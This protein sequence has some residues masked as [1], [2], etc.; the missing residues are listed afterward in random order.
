MKKT[1]FI[2]L[3]LL[4]IVGCSKPI[5]EESLKDRGGIKY[6]QDAQEPYSGKVFKLY[7]TGEKFLDGIYKDGKK[8]GLYTFWY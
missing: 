1:L 4:L 7:E 6:Q 8:D 3:P 2:L 5:D